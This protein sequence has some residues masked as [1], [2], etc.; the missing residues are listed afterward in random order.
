[1]PIPA[2]SDF[3]DIQ[4]LSEDQFWGLLRL[5]KVLKDERQRM[6]QNAPILAGKSLATVVSEGKPAHTRQL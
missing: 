1:M 4:S 3:L 2:M 5:A 6:G